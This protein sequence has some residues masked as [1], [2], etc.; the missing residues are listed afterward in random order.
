MDARGRAVVPPS[1]DV[2]VVSMPDAVL[3]MVTGR[4]TEENVALVDEVRDSLVVSG[5]SAEVI[6]VLWS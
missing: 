3:L 2:V 5:T 4:R 1:A 6:D